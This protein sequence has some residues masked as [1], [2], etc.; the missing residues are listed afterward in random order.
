LSTTL[1]AS[2]DSEP[3]IDASEVVAL[4]R[5]LGKRYDIHDRPHQRLLQYLWPPARRLGR[6]FWAL[7]DVDI[8]IRRGET[9]GIIGRNGS[10]KSTLLQLISGTIPP[11]EGTVALSGRVAALLELGAGFNPEFTGIENVV[12]NASILGLTQKQI[13][14]RLDDILAFADI[15]DFARQ[16]VKQYSSGMFLRLAFAVVAH[17]DADILVIDEALAVGDVLFVQ[18]CLRFLHQFRERGTLLFVSHD[19]GMVR[20]LC[21]RAIWFEQGGVRM[22]GDA[23]SVTHA[24]LEDVYGSQPAPAAAAA[25]VSPNDGRTDTLDEDTRREL[26]LHSNLRNDLQVSRFDPSASGFGTGGARITEVCFRD[27]GGRPLTAMVGGEPVTFEVQFVAERRLVGA[28]IGFMLKDHAGR[29]LFGQNTFLAYEP[30]PPCPDEGDI[31]TGRFHFRLPYLPMGE[32]AVTVSVTEGTQEDHLVHHWIHEA[33]VL[34]CNASHVTT[35][36]IG[37]PARAIEIGLD[38]QLTAPRHDPSTETACVA[39][40]PHCP[41][42]PTSD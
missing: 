12:L 24:Y 36:L 20:K 33:L 11:T 3:L 19:I 27:S 40:A 35:G 4:A 13:D 5:D 21:D 14:A 41:P 9:I 1:P 2:P 28:I 32:Y 6:E 8:E 23:E 22:M 39:P 38:A 16:P 37:V 34:R 31:G 17:V 26:L 15:G 10:G 29:V 7:R 18:K 42:T 30:S 25:A